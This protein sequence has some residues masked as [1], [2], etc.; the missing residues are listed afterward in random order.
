MP[1]ASSSKPEEGPVQCEIC[2]AVIQRRQDFPRHMRIHSEKRDEIYESLQRSNV[3][4]HHRIQLYDAEKVATIRHFPTPG[5]FVTNVPNVRPV[6][7]SSLRTRERHSTSVACLY[8][9]AVWFP[10]GDQQES[11][12]LLFGQRSSKRRHHKYLPSMTTNPIMRVF[13]D[14][15]IGIIESMLHQIQ[16]ENAFLTNNAPYAQLLRSVLKSFDH[17]DGKD[18]RP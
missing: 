9:T 3:D 8:N 11:L 15:A 16:G 10:L 17:F 2:Q 4:I 18:H 5:C 6:V 7:K 12:L 1:R 13:Q 14:T